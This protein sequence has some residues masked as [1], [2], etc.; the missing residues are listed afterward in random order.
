[1]RSGSSTA[2]AH[3]ETKSPLAAFERT[4]ERTQRGRFEADLNRATFVTLSLVFFG[5]GI[6]LLVGAA[7][8]FARRREFLA[9][10]A[11]ATGTVVNFAEPREGLEAS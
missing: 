2:L 6:A 9:G 1:M 11:V 4:R 5:A 8:Q 10:S 3:S 7:R